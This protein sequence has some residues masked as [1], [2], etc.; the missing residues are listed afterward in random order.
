MQKSMGGFKFGQNVPRRLVYGRLMSCRSPRAS[1]PKDRGTDAFGRVQII[2]HKARYRIDNSQSIALNLC[3]RGLRLH[4][5]LMQCQSL[6]AINVE[7][8]HCSRYSTYCVTGH[9]DISIVS[10]PTH[11]AA[12]I[13]QT[14]D[15]FAA[16]PSSSTFRVADHGLQ[17]LSNPSRHYRSVLVPQ[18]RGFTK[19]VYLDW[20][21]DTSRQLD[22]CLPTKVQPLIA[23]SFAG[24][25][26]RTKQALH[27]GPHA[28]EQH[29][30]PH[31]LSAPRS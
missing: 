10:Q 2:V 31:S 16:E 22:L 6:H 1:N 30:A 17:N 26:L 5:E 3:Q 21:H 8:S 27:R 19:K 28:L 25:P 15:Q 20:S 9:K 11:Q 18:R 13:L 29:T 14:A 12:I 4:R 24:E 7:F 23:L